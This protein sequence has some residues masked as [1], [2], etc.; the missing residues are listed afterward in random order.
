MYTIIV[1]GVNFFTFVALL[2][3]SL[4]AVKKTFFD[5]STSRTTNV[6]VVSGPDRRKSGSSLIYCGGPNSKYN[7]LALCVCTEKG[8]YSIA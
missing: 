1:T 5:G 8:S 6:R 7:Y 4:L 2:S 3:A